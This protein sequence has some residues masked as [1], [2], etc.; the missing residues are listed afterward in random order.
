MFLSKIASLASGT[1]LLS[2]SLFM[3]LDLKF[4]SVGTSLMRNFGRSVHGV[5]VKWGHSFLVATTWKIQVGDKNRSILLCTFRGERES[6]PLQRSLIRGGFRCSDQ[7]ADRLHRTVSTCFNRLLWK[8][9]PLPPDSFSAIYTKAS[10][11]K[12]LL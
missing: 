5:W 7:W 9:R 3:G 6:H 12:F 11:P 8:P 2:V 4:H 10:L 1:S